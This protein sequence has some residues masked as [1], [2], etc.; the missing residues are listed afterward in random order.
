MFLKGNF[1]ESGTQGF[2]NAT[3]IGVVEAKSELDPWKTETHVSDL[4]KRQAW[5]FHVYLFARS[6]LCRQPKPT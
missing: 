3:G 4:P 2:K 6:R 5:F 1:Y